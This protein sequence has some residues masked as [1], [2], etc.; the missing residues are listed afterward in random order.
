MPKYSPQ[1][2]NIICAMLQ[3]VQVQKLKEVDPLGA[4]N[5]GSILVFDSIGPWTN[6]TFLCLVACEF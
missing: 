4:E 3:K 2:Q 1:T 6:S 5:A